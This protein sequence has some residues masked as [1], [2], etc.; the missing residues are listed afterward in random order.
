MEAKYYVVL[1][2]YTEGQYSS[3]SY[4]PGV[5]GLALRDDHSPNFGIF[6]K[7]SSAEAFAHSQVSVNGGVELVVCE[8]YMQVY[9]K[10]SEVKVKLWK[11]SELLP[12]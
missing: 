5:S 7:K 3:A 2:K 10:P 6:V 1:P 12:L 4:V 11:G 8:A 9:A